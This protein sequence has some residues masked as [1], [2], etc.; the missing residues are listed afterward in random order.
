MYVCIYYTV[1]TYKNK[2]KMWKKGGEEKCWVMV[3]QILQSWLQSYKK[4][5]I[6]L[7][8]LINILLSVEYVNFY[9]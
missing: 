7:I 2:K 5:A 8:L 3:L 6:L 9:T 4:L 1:Y